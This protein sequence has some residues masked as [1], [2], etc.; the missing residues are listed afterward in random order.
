MNV[1]ITPVCMQRMHHYDGIAV[2]E[3]AVFHKCPLKDYNVHTCTE[4]NMRVVVAEF[5]YISGN[6]LG[7]THIY[8][9][10]GLEAMKTVSC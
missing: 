1:S 3:V 10:A 6:V 8:F 2:R 9:E 4:R 7:I 5:D